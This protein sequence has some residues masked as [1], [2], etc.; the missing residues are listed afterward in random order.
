MT[1]YCSE[2]AKDALAS[3]VGFAEYLRHSKEYETRSLIHGMSECQELNDLVDRTI[4]EIYSYS[5]QSFIDSDKKKAW[6]EAIDRFRFLERSVKFK[7]NSTGET[8]KE[9]S[10]P[11]RVQQEIDNTLAILIRAF[12]I[13]RVKNEYWQTKISKVS[14]IVSTLKDHIELK[15]IT[16]PKNEED[17]ICDFIETHIKDENGKSILRETIKMA[18]SRK[19]DKRINYHNNP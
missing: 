7:T 18:L 15:E 3:P 4:K 6:K 1:D 2:L 13:R 5:M 12:L 14:K 19:N 11:E 17:N 16:I 10:T 9:Y 8:S